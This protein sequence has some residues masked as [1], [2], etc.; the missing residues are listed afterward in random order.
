M[1]QRGSPTRL[2]STRRPTWEGRM[3]ERKPVKGHP[4]VTE[5]RWV[6]RAGKKQQRYDAVLWGPDSRKHSRSFARLTDADRWLRD[7]RTG[8]DRGLWIDPA[9]GRRT[10]GSFAS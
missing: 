3:M 1:D 4:G 9:L 7:Q 5:R 8:V 10:F 2:S 6:D